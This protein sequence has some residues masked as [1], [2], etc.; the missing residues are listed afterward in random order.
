M[1]ELL[2][3]S[4][5]NGPPPYN[6]EI[7]VYNML[8]A[9]GPTADELYLLGGVTKSEVQGRGIFLWNARTNAFTNLGTLPATIVGNGAIGKVAGKIYIVQGDVID[10]YDTIGKSWSKRTGLPYGSIYNFTTQASVTY[11]GVLY[12]F[13][14]STSPAGVYLKRYNHVN[15]TWST[16]A[17]YNTT[18]N[19]GTSGKGVVIGNMAYFFGGGGLEKLI[20]SYNFTT[21]AFAQVTMPGSSQFRSVLGVY[22]G[23]VIFTPYNEPNAPFTTDGKKIM[24]FDPSNNAI[25]VAA[26]TNPVK[27][28]A[29]GVVIDNLF[30]AYGGRN[31]VT[32]KPVDDIQS[33]SV[34]LS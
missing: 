17:T 2:M 8:T 12:Y 18:T 16:E 33:I 10:V 7:G 6:G 5:A 3:S 26:E 19:N 4:T 1:L 21:K 22:N 20:I 15:N 11:N 27:V 14:A 28:T 24:M 29:A 32:N 30:K 23:K 34:G 9:E 13:G 31:S 25:T